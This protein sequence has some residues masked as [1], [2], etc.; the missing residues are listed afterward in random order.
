MSKN[1]SE[2]PIEV[3][4]CLW[5]YDPARLDL[6]RDRREIITQVLNYGTWS[7]VK[8]LRTTYTDEELR[9]VLRQPARGRWFKTSLNFWLLQFNMTLPPELLQRALFHIGPV[10]TA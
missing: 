10:K 1:S 5:S 3:R 2:L 7:A 4:A 9:E 6:K 8:W